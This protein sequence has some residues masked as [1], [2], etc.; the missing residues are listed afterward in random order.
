MICNIFIGIWG[1][2]FVT[3]IGEATEYHVVKKEYEMN[4]IYIFDEVYTCI[5]K[6]EIVA[7]SLYDLYPL[8]EVLE[9]YLI[10]VRELYHGYLPYKRTN[11][12]VEIARC[13]W[14]YI[15]NICENVTELRQVENQI[16]Y[17][18]E[19][20]KRYTRDGKN[21]EKIDA[22]IKR[23]DERKVHLLNEKSVLDY[24]EYAKRNINELHLWVT[25]KKVKFRFSKKNIRYIDDTIEQKNM[26]RKLKKD[27]RRFK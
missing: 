18:S 7:K 19:I 5:M 6:N 16:E 17:W 20:K 15:N 3:L 27:L 1:S 13:M 11:K 10:E 26:M 4:I 21:V 23:Y 8:E 24:I 9:N 14:T 2:A 25:G 22:L 12:Y